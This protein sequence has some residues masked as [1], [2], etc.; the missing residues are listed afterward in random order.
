MAPIGPRPKLLCKG[1]RSYIDASNIV[2]S[3]AE[4]V[5]DTN[6]HSI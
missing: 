6:D 5:C 4:I 3:K 1:K 2:N